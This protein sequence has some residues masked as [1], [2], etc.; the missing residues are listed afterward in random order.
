MKIT[1]S[2]GGGAE[3][4]VQHVH[5]D[6]L[7]VSSSLTGVQAV[8]AVA[9][10]LALPPNPDPPKAEPVKAPVKSAPPKAGV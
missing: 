4:R 7:V 1:I 6:D 8:E 9:A 10:W 2:G 3:F 5:R